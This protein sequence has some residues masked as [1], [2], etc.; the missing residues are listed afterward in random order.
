MFIA[1]LA[2]AVEAVRIRSPDEGGMIA[3]FWIIEAAP[4][5]LLWG[6]GKA[7]AGIG[8]AVRHG[9]GIGKYGINIGKKATE[10]K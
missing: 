7:V 8:C 6:N 5:E 10:S 3:A 2:V 4:A 1:W 9:R